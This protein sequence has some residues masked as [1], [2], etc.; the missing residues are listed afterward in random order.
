MVSA[1]KFSLSNRNEIS[2]SAT[3]SST[4]TKQL[5]SSYIY[6]QEM[7]VVIPISA[8]LEKLFLLGLDRILASD[9]PQF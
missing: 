6:V 8:E 7:I 5:Y 9:R 1:V 3:S 2:L 4:C